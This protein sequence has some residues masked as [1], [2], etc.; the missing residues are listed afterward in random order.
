MVLV[1]IA[2]VEHVHRAEEPFD[3][4]YG[5]TIGGGLHGAVSGN[6]QRVLYGFGKWIR[7]KPQFYLSTLYFQV[8]ISCSPGV[9]SVPQF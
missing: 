5:F 9:K 7:K 8:L 4:T 3:Y 1:G 6:E 2:G